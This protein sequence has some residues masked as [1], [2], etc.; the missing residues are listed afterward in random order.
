LRLRLEGS[1]V[2]GSNLPV[3]EGREWFSYPQPAGAP[4]HEGWGIVDAVGDDV[5]GW[6]VG[7]RVASL[8]THAFAETEIVAADAVVR[9]PPELDGQP[10]PGE[11]LGCAMNVFRR[12]GIGPGQT[13]AIIGIGFLGALLTQLCSRAGARGDRAVAPCLRAGRRAGVRRREM[14]LRWTTTMAPSSACVR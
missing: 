2:C 10:F 4:G 13:V 7:E 14:R 8:G 3:W 1:G 11:P 9:L 6:Q 12:S 5:R